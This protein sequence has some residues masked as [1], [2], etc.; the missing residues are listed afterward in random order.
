MLYAV[1]DDRYRPE[2]KLISDLTD[3]FNYVTHYRCLKFY[4][5]Q[6]LRLAKI[7]RV[8]AFD[9]KA[10]MT[11]FI[12]YCNEMRK[13]AKTEFES[14]LWKLFPNST[15]GKCIENVRN[16]INLRLIVDKM[17]LTRAAAKASFKRAEIINE[18]LVLV[19]TARVRVKLCKPIAVGVT[20]LELS[21]LIMFDFYYNCIQPKFGQRMEL[22]LTDTDSFICHIQSDDL[23]A[24]MADMRDRFDTS[25]FSLTHPLY[26]TANKRA[27]GKFKSE[28]GDVI[29]LELCAL[30]SKMYSLLTDTDEH[31]RAKGI[32]KFYV[33][34]R[35]KHEDYLRVLNDWRPTR[36]EFQTFRSRR[37]VVTT[38]KMRKLSLSCFDTKRYLLADGITSLAYG[39]WRI[40]GGHPPQGGAPG[41]AAPPLPGKG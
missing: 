17:K 23:H 26:S 4:L 39:H 40:N 30:R 3:K 10:F 1:G 29:P 9:Q 22:C 28:T 27:L 18:D 41:G 14:N 8:L 20:I 5:Q 11:P 31:K 25:N 33:K 32:P 38:R 7:H 35:L 12:N 13:N 15:Y 34:R 24:E 21:K 36:C 16:R 19:E 37:H 6:G 2:T